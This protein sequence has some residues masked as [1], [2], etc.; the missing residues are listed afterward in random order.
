MTRLS[1]FGPVRQQDLVVRE[2]DPVDVVD[3]G[4]FMGGLLGDTPRDGHAIDVAHV[5]GVVQAGRGEAHRALIPPFAIAP[6]R[7]PRERVPV[8][9][10]SAY[11]CHRAR[12]GITRRHVGPR[13]TMIVL[14]GSDTESIRSPGNASRWFFQLGALTG[15]D[16]RRRWN[17]ATR[18]KINT[19]AR[20]ARSRGGGGRMGVLDGFKAVCTWSADEVRAFLEKEGQGEYNLVDVRQPGEYEQ[21]HLPGAQLIPLGELPER[22]GELDREKA[23]IVY[24]AAGVRSRA[25]AAILERAGFKKVLNMSG[26]I[27]A[28]RGAV[29]SGFPE[30][31]MQYFAPAA[32]MGELVALARVLEEGAREFYA[33]IADTI[34]DRRAAALFADL[35]AGEA[36]HEAM[37]S[38]M[39][40]ESTGE[41]AEAGASALLGERAGERIMEGGMRVDE[42]VAWAEGR[43]TTEIAEFALSMEAVSYDRYQAM[44]ESAGT[45]PAREL[46]TRLAAEEKSHLTRLTA[47]FERAL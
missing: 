21:G 23:A 47:M 40:L 29:A 24:C 14:S 27:G 45:P 44:A 3:E 20:D 35:V 12:G 34:T 42:A 17:A 31:G 8:P 7:E 33:R 4:A 5:D 6:E 26:G 46:F 11:R 19:A 13:S 37:L 28:W 16:P 1:S 39:Y 38:S 30:S 2:P 15:R 22:W 25:A 36:Q 32:S 10:V 9:C 43:S 18:S 41:V